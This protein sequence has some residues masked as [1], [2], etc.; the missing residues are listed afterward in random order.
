MMC[1]GEELGV[2]AVALMPMDTVLG[3][4]EGYSFL[5][6]FRLGKL[7]DNFRPGKLVT[8]SLSYLCI[9]DEPVSHLFQ[10]LIWDQTLLRDI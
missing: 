2:S 10:Y 6:N 5:G 8:G 9:A 4:P 7:L 3:T 1:N